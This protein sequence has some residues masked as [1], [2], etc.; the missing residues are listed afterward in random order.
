MKK[1]KVFYLMVVNGDERWM[2]LQEAGKIYDSGWFPVKIEG[3]VMDEDG[4]QR[5]ITDEERKKI[6]EIANRRSESK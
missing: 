2:T 6:V 3:R 5:P 4:E 1:G